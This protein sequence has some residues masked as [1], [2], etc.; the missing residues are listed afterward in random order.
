M[1]QKLFA[2]DPAKAATID[3]DTWLNKPGPAPR[4]P[5]HHQPGPG[6]G[7]RRAR[8]G[9]SPGAAAGGLDTKGWVTQQWQHFIKTLPDGHRPRHA[10][11]SWTPPSA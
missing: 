2:A 9:S 7:G 4:R 10:W 6:P 1:K 11:P 3:L 5:P 8:S